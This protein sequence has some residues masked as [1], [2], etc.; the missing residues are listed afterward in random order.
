MSD[1]KEKQ[2]NQKGSLE[3]DDDVEM[4]DYDPSGSNSQSF[5]EDNKRQQEGCTSGN[6]VMDEFIK[7]TP[8]QTFYEFKWI[9]Y[10]RLKDITYDDSKG[11]HVALLID[12]N[13]ELGINDI[14][15]VGLQCFNEEKLSEVLS[16]EIVIGLKSIIQETHISLGYLNSNNILIDDFNN[17][18]ISIFTNFRQGSNIAYAAPEILEGNKVSQASYI[19]SLGMVFYKIIFEQEPLTRFNDEDRSQFGRDIPEFITKCWKVVPSDRPTINELVD[20][21][22]SEFI[23]NYDSSQIKQ[24]VNRVFSSEQ[25]SNILEQATRTERFHNTRYNETPEQDYNYQEIDTSFQNGIIFDPN[26]HNNNIFSENSI[27]VYKSLPQKY[28]NN[29]LNHGPVNFIKPR[30]DGGSKFADDDIADEFNKIDK[31]QITNIQKFEN[32]Q[33]NTRSA[34][35]ANDKKVIIKKLQKLQNKKSILVRKKVYEDCN[36]F[37]IIPFA[38]EGNLRNYLKD[39]DFSIEKKVGIAIKIADGIKYLHI[40]DIIHENLHPKNILM[41]EGMA[42][43]SDLPLPYEKNKSVFFDQQFFDNIGYIDPDSLLNEHFVKNKSM[44]IYSF[45]SLLWEIMSGKVPYSKDKDEGILQLVQKIKD[46]YREGNIIDAHKYELCK[47][48]WNGKPSDRP[49]IE[50]VFDELLHFI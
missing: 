27:S 25:T 49:T 14:I 3:L 39:K 34:M 43:I 9:N 6:E 11:F 24:I 44:D 33:N 41:F 30:I 48:C 7:K 29:D 12:G 31:S 37:L 17:A 46:G 42:Q 5:Y 50:E 16:Q 20:F 22:S 19:Y 13:I 32:C 4:L 15:K 21:F 35:L 26:K 1:F 28:F 10:N 18:R 36:T 23:F 47:L 8:F 45:G 2:E 40:K 38:P